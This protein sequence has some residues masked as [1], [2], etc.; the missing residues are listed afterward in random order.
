[1]ISDK[2]NL[3]KFQ[4]ILAFVGLLGAALLFTP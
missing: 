1:M 3:M 2:T 4:A